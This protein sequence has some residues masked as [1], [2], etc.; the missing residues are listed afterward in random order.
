M[1]ETIAV[2]ALVACILNQRALMM[3]LRQ[4]RR[5]PPDDRQLPP[6]S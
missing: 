5:G 3:V 4:N 6:G 2:L 1:L